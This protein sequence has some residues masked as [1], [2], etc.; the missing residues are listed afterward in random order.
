VAFALQS[1]EYVRIVGGA[2]TASSCCSPQ[3]AP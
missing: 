2:M 3:V 1:R